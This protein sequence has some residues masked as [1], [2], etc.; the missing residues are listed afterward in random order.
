MMYKYLYYEHIKNRYQVLP[1]QNKNMSKVKKK[2]ML[3]TKICEV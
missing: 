1:K 2:K 3:I